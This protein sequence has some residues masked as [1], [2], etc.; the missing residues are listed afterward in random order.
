VDRAQAL[1]ELPDKYAIALRLHDE[2]LEPE[3]VGRVLD[4]EPEAVGPLLTLA[5]AKLAGL[6]DPQ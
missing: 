4:V 2:G 3:A 6:M 5:E 1:Q